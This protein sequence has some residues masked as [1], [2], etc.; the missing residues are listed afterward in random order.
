MEHKL[1]PAQVNILSP[2]LEQ[3]QA[4]LMELIALIGGAANVT[5]ANPRLERREGAWYLVADAAKGEAG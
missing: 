4:A 5:G 2:L 1:T 3:H